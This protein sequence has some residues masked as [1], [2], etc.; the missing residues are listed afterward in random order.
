MV[1]NGEHG[2]NG[3]GFGIVRAINQASNA[4]VDER[5]GAH[6]ARFNCSK[7]VTVAQ[8][9]VTEVLRGI[10]QRDDFGMSGW[11]VIG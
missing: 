10:A 9:M 11:I 4:G 6:R 1:E 3:S 2:V 7:Q 8:T 5:S